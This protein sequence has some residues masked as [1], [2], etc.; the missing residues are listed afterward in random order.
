MTN[1][2]CEHFPRKVVTF[3]IWGSYSDS[4]SIQ[5]Y[6]M[7]YQS[8]YQPVGNLKILNQKILRG[9]CSHTK[10]VTEYCFVL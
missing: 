1:I 9:K 4:L 10:F 8:K 2:A 5:R 3:G 7:L 6:S